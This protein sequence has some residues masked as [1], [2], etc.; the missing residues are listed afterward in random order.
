MKKLICLFFSLFFLEAHA[1]DVVNVRYIHE[2]LEHNYG[3]FVPYNDGL[4]DDTVAANMK[5]LLTVVD[6]ANNF[7]TG[8]MTN[9]AASAYATEDA[10]D[11]VV[12]KQAFDT[13][14]KDVVV[15]DVD[16]PFEVGAT[17]DSFSF[18]MSAQGEFYID[19][20]DGNKETITKND[21]Q[22]LTY[23]HSYSGAASYI[24]KFGGVATDY[25]DDI[26]TATI[27]FA[28]NASITSFTGNLSMIFPTLESGKNPRFYNSFSGLTGFSG[29]M[30]ANLFIDLT[31]AP[32]ANM[33]NGTFKNTTNIRGTIPADVFG[34]LTGAPA[35]GMFHSTFYGLRQL[36]NGIPANL[37]EGIVGPPAK[38]MFNSTFYGC[39]KL[40]NNIPAG[41]FAGISGQPAQGM[42]S[43]TFYG[44]TKLS[45]I[46]D[47]VFG[48]LSGDAQTDMFTKTFYND[49]KLYGYSPKI[50]GQ[51]LY[52]I[53]PNA[54]QAQVGDAF[55][56]CQK[57]SDYGSI[58]STWR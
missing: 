17:A 32:V 34:N 3:I 35:E 7:L 13:L 9:Y 47:G 20:G 4:I 40:R 43:Q 22:N 31:G 19:W 44:C 25:N 14:I 15:L 1:D 33:F 5:Y 48:D 8:T 24:I 11:T 53:W 57:L 36:G 45:G 26:T 55:Y 27:S 37:F 38:D 29:S 18:S 42:F 41:L 23:S 39:A 28:N 6:I 58:P 51:Y 52:Q 12:A 2:L 10:A 21:T 16:Y 56:K 30:P 50:N 54:T 49:N 46:D